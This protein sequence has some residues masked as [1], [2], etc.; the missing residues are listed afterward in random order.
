MT[1]DVA[2]KPEIKP[3]SLMVS[4]I[5][6]LGSLSAVTPTNLFFVL[7]PVFHA[8]ALAAESVYKSS[9]EWVV[10]IPNTGILSIAI[11][12]SGPPNAIR[13]KSI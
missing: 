13:P 11:L 5:F 1:D 10:T 12:N 3:K 7:K 6:F 2:T 4:E 8:V 9:T